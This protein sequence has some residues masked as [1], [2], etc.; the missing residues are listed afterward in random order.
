MEKDK[1]LKVRIDD[2]TDKRLSDLE[3]KYGLTRSEIVRRSI[4]A[5]DADLLHYSMWITYN[6]P[7]FKE[8]LIKKLKEDYS[9]FNET[10][11]NNRRFIIC[12]DLIIGR[13]ED[14][15]EKRQYYTSEIEESIRIIS[16]DRLIDNEKRLAEMAQK[17]ID[18]YFFELD[19][20]IR[21]VYGIEL[22][23]K[24]DD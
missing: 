10:F 4:G 2:Y 22:Y 1:I 5:Y 18:K 7:Y 13:R 24:Y 15:N 6:M 20:E 14:L 23:N 9:D 16:Y 21:N 17:N 12:K 3:K 8:I 19:D 11:Q